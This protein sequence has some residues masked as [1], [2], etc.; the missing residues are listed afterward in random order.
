MSCRAR[1][2]ETDGPMLLIGLKQMHDQPIQL[3]KSPADR[4][5]RARLERRYERFLRAS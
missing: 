1:L 4:P 3:P 2:E 5:D